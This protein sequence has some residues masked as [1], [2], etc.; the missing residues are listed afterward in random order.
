M[1]VTVD[2]Y[3]EELSKSEHEHERTYVPSMYR[4]RATILGDLFGE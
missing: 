3:E 4:E 2:D 1:R